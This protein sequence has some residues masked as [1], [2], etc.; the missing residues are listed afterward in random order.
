MSDVIGSAEIEIRATKKKLKQ[1]ADAAKRE[2]QQA[3]KEIEKA[4]GDA[5][6]GAARKFGVA[7]RQME[8]DAR[9]VADNLGARYRELGTD[10]GRSMMGASRVAQVA[11]AG[12][13][14]YSIKAASE[15]E[16][17]GD[18]FAFTFSG[19]S[20]QADATAQKIATDFQR[21]TTQVKGNLTTLYQVVTG[22]GID[23]ATAF[24][25]SSQITT[26][27]LD[28]ASQKG[29]S[30]ARAF[31][32][33]LGGITGETE[34][35]KNLGVVITEAAVKAELLRMGFKGNAE[36]ATEAQKATAR[37]NLILAKTA[38][39][40]GDVART[41]ESAANKA[42]AMQT[43]FQ[44]SAVALGE[45]LLPAF[46][47][48]AGAATDTLKAFND[49]PG[50][51]QVA[52]LAIL[53]FIAAGGPIAGL[54][55]NLGK[56][57]KLA[58]DTRLALM[59]VS[60]AQA[61]A[62]GSGAA[63]AAGAAAGGIGLAGSAAVGAGLGLVAAGA[64]A[65]DSGRDYLKAKKALDKATDETLATAIAYASA[66][67]T[68]IGKQ[69]AGPN[70]ERIRADLTANL[71]RFQ[72]E[73]QRRQR[74]GRGS[75]AGSASVDT[76]VLGG[77]G[78]PLG[79]GGGASTRAGRERASAADKIAKETEREIAEFWKR[80]SAGKGESYQA[81]LDQ[82]EKSILEVDG[83]PSGFV[84]A[85]EGALGDALAGLSEQ[86]EAAKEEFRYMFSD[87]LMAALSGDKDAVARWFQDVTT[88]GLQNSLDA[89]ADVIFDLFSQAG[90]SGGAG[91]GGGFWATA[92]KAVGSFF[93][94]GKAGGGDV[95]AG[96]K[97][98]VGERGPEFFTAPTNGMIIPNT[99]G[100]AAPAGGSA[101]QRLIVQLDLKSDMLDARIDSRA[102]PMAAQ[103]AVGAVQQVRTDNAKAA[104]RRR[105]SFG[106]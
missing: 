72:V 21:T 49:L 83:N 29:I 14:A 16:D 51:V 12:I 70:G 81:F 18:A 58:R 74:A 36:G 65:P 89:L 47:K 103:A 55:A 99:R 2:I 33:V 41:S 23:S 10:I 97:Y 26:R 9:R 80:L 79:G 95:L 106:G 24:A 94:G 40:Q 3:T 7:Q 17:I 43:E 68:R 39:A 13:V 28:L 77:F 35:L 4:Y 48:V 46:V 61:A 37:L 100:A 69:G 64:L 62:G 53:G 82:F 34:P 84:A 52:G 91:G 101:L 44:N 102:A 22:F 105:Y 15:A 19:M 67:I 86:R 96:R 57:I 31:Q 90:S 104:G 87:G 59:A 54:L 63:V 38:S 25:M 92:A 56:V 75:D 45:Q 60:G 71:Y 32:A 78:L 42:K 8:A 85:G 66:N 5:G 88:R 73:Q 50:G 1:D 98:L 11:F 6:Q 93:G 27:A 20:K 76:S 30:D